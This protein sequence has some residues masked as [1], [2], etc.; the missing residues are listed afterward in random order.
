MSVPDAV[1]AAIKAQASLDL[2]PV[3]GTE[4]FSAQCLKTKILQF[5]SGATLRL[6]RLDLPFLVISA[7]LVLLRAPLVRA[8]ITRDLG[9]SAISGASGVGGTSGINGA[10][11]A[12]GIDGANGAAGSA[13]HTRQLPPIYL[14]V[15]DILVQ[16]DGPVNWFD[17]SIVVSGVD[18]ASGGTGGSG[19][20]GGAG[21]PGV[22]A[23]GGGGIAIPPGNGGRGGTGGAGGSGGQGGDGGALIYVGPQVALDKMSWIKV[24]NTGGQG[25]PG[26]K[27]GHGGSGGLGG[28][29]PVMP[30]NL[31]QAPAVPG[32]VGISGNPGLDG[33]AGPAGI[34][35]T[36][37]VVI[38]S[39]LDNFYS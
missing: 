8:T 3:T 5:D 38:Q 27:G 32:L 11:G 6:S 2:F 34:K 15:E 20:N 12:N 4:T 7:R 17:L 39:S 19:G 31:L 30:P 23:V 26:G 22:A 21:G 9:V 18:G 16:P 33:P 37:T 10:A 28:P 13:G 14:L 29:A 35:G 1:V 25:G 24:M 36:V